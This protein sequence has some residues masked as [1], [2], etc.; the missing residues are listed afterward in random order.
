MGIRPWGG[1]TAHQTAPFV[2]A[3]LVVFCF[4]PFWSL[5]AFSFHQQRVHGFD[6]FEA[7]ANFLMGIR[8]ALDRIR[9]CLMLSFG[10]PFKQPGYRASRKGQMDGPELRFGHQTSDPTFQLWLASFWFFLKWV[11][12]FLLTSPKN[13]PV[14]FPLGFPFGFLLER[15]KAQSPVPEAEPGRHGVERLARLPGPPGATANC[16][17]SILFEA[18]RV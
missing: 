9:L 12:L 18:T 14:W 2:I 17:A 3:R 1:L 4:W 10:F 6:I 7:L 13:R 8:P 15:P 16:Q 5:F 11:C